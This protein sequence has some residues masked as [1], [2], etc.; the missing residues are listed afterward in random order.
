M[1]V[2]YCVLSRMSCLADQFLTFQFARGTELKQ[3]LDNKMKVETMRNMNEIWSVLSQMRSVILI[4]LFSLGSGS[5][6]FISISHFSC[7]EN[8]ETASNQLINVTSLGQKLFSA[9]FHKE[10]KRSVGR[11]SVEKLLQFVK[12]TCVNF[13]KDTIT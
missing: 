7:L 6:Q 13:V 12:D 5:F 2:S 1:F 10:L 11:E 3:L 8:N 4:T 9:F